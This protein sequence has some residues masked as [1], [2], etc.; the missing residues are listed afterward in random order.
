MSYKDQKLVLDAHFLT[1]TF[2]ERRGEK[3]K[4]ARAWEKIKLW[5]DSLPLFASKR[6]RNLQEN[7]LKIFKVRKQNPNFTFYDFDIGGKSPNLRKRVS[8]ILN[9]FWS[10]F[11]WISWWIFYMGWIRGG[12]WKKNG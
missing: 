8:L 5:C 4:R 10:C 1:I 9:H 11:G 3:G 12:L 2:L 6:A 7:D